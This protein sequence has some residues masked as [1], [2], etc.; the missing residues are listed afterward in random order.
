MDW[1]DPPKIPSEITA[2]YRPHELEAVVKAIGRT[3]PHKLRDSTMIMVPYDIG[4]R[5]AQLRVMKVDDLVH[6]SHREG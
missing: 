6:S 5:A 4:V 1:V 2:Y 3:I